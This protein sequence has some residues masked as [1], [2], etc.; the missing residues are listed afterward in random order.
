M[1]DKY[2]TPAMLGRAIERLKTQAAT[3][4]KV[5][6]DSDALPDDLP[7]GGVAI[8]VGQ[9]GITFYTEDGKTA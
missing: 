5:L 3:Q 9:N 4:V 8:V 2:I 6:N 7:K 1:V